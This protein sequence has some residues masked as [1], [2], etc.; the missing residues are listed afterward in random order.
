MQQPVGYR[1]EWKPGDYCYYNPEDFER[2][3]FKAGARIHGLFE[4]PQPDCPAEI[5][6]YHG[7]YWVQPKHV[8]GDDITG[9]T[10]MYLG[11]CIY[12]PVDHEQAAAVV[13]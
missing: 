2:E 6:V 4:A 12:D 7:N 9:F 8:H 5:N 1:L 10:K 11:P 3:T 13:Q